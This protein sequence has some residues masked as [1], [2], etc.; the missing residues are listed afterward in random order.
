MLL[1]RLKMESNWSFGICLTNMYRVYCL[2]FCLVFHWIVTSLLPTLC[3]AL[4]RMRMQYPKVWNIELEDT[5][6]SLSLK[7]S[8]SFPLFP[9]FH[10]VLHHQSFDTVL[11]HQLFYKLKLSGNNHKHLCQGI[12]H[13]CA[14]HLS[15]VDNSTSAPHTWSRI[16]SVFFYEKDYNSPCLWTKVVETKSMTLFIMDSKTLSLWTK[17]SGNK[18]Y[19]LVH[20]GFQNSLS[21]SPPKRV[22]T[23]STRLFIMV[24][25]P[26]FSLST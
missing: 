1:K 7:S 17:V 24:P 8:S 16:R 19:D 3:L 26:F 4:S 5:K 12:Q 15:S 6:I 10:L 25:K 14:W 21:L 20:H 22:E 13:R 18:I 11:D 23:K 2:R 9:P